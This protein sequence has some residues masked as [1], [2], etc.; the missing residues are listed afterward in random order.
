MLD[1]V[2]SQME[3]PEKENSILL[4]KGNA[5]NKVSKHRSGSI[6]NSLG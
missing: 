5:I 3:T 4:V 6:Y 1:Y 2:F